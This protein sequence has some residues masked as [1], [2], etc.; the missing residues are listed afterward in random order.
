ME[1]PIKDNRIVS[2]CTFALRLYNFLKDVQVSDAASSEEQEYLLNIAR[3]LAIYQVN[4]SP[5]SEL[6]YMVLNSD[7]FDEI[8]KHGNK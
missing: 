7:T 4:T 2:D 8:L 3:E 1:N 5:D 6:K